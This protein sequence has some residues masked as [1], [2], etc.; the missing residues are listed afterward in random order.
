[1]GANVCLI[2]G[3]TKINKPKNVK[4]FIKVKTADEMF[5]KCLKNIPK[6]LFISVAAVSDWK[7]KNYSKNKIKKKY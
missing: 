5:E 2:S 6:D 3:P 4:N 7:I 1:M